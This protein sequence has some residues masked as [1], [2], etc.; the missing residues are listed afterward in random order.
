MICLNCDKEYEATGKFCSTRCKKYA[1]RKRDELT[2]IP[3][4]TLGPKVEQ[5][6]TIDGCPAMSSVEVVRESQLK[7]GDIKV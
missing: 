7:R 3:D 2:A 6:D 4:V 5:E 1:Q